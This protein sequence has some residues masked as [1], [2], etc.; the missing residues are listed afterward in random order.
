MLLDTESLRMSYTKRLHK[1]NKIYNL[2]NAISQ[3]SGSMKSHTHVFILKP[4]YSLVNGENEK[5]L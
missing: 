1:Y 2:L 3:L 5:I 4:K